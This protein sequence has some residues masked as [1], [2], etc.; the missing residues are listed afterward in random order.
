MG[1]TAGK[2]RKRSELQPGF[3]ISG[4]FGSS[5][6]K[7]TFENGWT[8]SVQFG[9]GTYSSNHNFIAG[10]APG[11]AIGAKQWKSGTAE[12][13]AWDKDNVWHVF[14]DGDTVSGWKLPNEVLAFM[15][16]IAEKE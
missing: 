4:L 2:K 12:I 14:P 8:V 11:A 5:G 10:L 7:L 9:P 16:E 13:A 1:T 3:E 6:F 15:H